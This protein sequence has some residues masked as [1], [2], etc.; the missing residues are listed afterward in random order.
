MVE[1][2]KLSLLRAVCK[3]NAWKPRAEVLGDVG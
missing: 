3:R 2:W 1:E